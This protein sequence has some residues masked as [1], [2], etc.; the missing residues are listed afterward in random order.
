MTS[1]ISDM[2]QDG[3]SKMED[4]GGF[5]PYYLAL[6]IDFQ[7]LLWLQ[8]PWSLY[9]WYMPYNLHQS[10]SPYRLCHHRRFPLVLAMVAP[11]RLLFETLEIKTFDFKSRNSLGVNSNI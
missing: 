3:R 9:Q 6:L 5:N 11:R 2:M 1:E 7:G 10:K 4:G 8:K